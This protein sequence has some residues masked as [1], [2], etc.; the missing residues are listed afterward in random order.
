MYLNLFQQPRQ[1]RIQRKDQ[2]ID[3]PDLALGNIR[4]IPIHK[5]RHRQPKLLLAVALREKLFQN[6]LGPREVDPGDLRRVR[7]VAGMKDLWEGERGLGGRDLALTGLW[8]LRMSP[9][10]LCNSTKLAVPRPF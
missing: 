3:E 7:D 6:L 10:M 9:E 1:R 4:R 8:G 2:D 5:H